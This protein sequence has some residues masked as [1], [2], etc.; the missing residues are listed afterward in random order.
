MKLD[1]SQRASITGNTPIK[2][3]FPDRLSDKLLRESEIKYACT[4]TDNGYFMKPIFGFTW[5]RN[6]FTPEITISVSQDGEKTV[7][8][9][10]GQPINSVQRFV[11]FYIS[12]ALLIEVFVLAIAAF[13]E[14]DSI[15]PL[16]IPIVM[17]IFGYSLCKFATKA[18]FKTVV[19]TISKVLQ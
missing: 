4:S 2:T 16:F 6:S 17:C 3:D 11:K 14:L 12:F 5:R 1:F 10:T 9:L 18:D 15:I 8:H 13:S 19:N 7:L